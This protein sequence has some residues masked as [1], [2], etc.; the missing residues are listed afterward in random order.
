[1]HSI[2]RFSF[3]LFSGC[4]ICGQF[5]E[6]ILQGQAHKL[7][8]KDRQIFFCKAVK[9]QLTY[10]RRSICLD[11]CFYTAFFLTVLQKV[12]LLYRGDTLQELF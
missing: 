2:V 9:Q 11:F 6:D 8:A 5:K 3:R 12:I 7:H 10:I 1:M 4:I